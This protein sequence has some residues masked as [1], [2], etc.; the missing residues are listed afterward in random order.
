MAVLWSL[1]T[2]VCS[3]SGKASLAAA[4]RHGVCHPANSVQLVS[5]SIGE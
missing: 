5:T 1:I 2:D 3:F 4:N